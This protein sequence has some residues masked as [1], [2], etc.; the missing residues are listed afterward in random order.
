M[1]HARSRFSLPEPFSLLPVGLYDNQFG[2][3]YSQP[4]LRNAGGLLDRTPY[5]T[6]KISVA[7]AALQAEE[8]QETFLLELAMRFVTWASLS[9]QYD[10]TLE[11]LKLAEKQYDR[12]EDKHR[13]FLVDKI[14]VLRAADAVRA[15]E[16]RVRLMQS[17]R[18]A[19]GA[20]LA[21]L[22]QDS[23]L[24]QFR[25]A[26]D[27]E[28]RAPLPALGDANRLLQSPVRVL[29]VFELRRKV[30]QREHQAL[31]EEKKPDLSLQIGVSRIGGG[32][33]ERNLLNANKQD[34][35]VGL[36]FTMPLGNRIATARANQ[37]S[38]RVRQIEL[39]S[40][41]TTLELEALLHNLLVQLTELN[42]VITIDDLQ[43]ASARA[44]TAE[45]L[46]QYN[47]G[48]SDLTFVIQ[49]QDAEQ[50]A[51]LLRIRNATTYHQL[52]LQLDGLLDRFSPAQARPSNSHNGG[53]S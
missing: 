31:L 37:G 5:E 40:Q 22:A 36:R 24:R 15:G 30:A 14:D 41:Q 1:G 47:Q 35:S 20:E 27:F 2:I 8:D 42:K 16:A 49:A 52:S 48:R 32:P 18:D 39:L 4:L 7:I 44:K 10:I 45:E 34:F 11:R 25:P 53:A 51:R 43:I 23:Q 50:D 21:V 46:E 19:A 28:S 13:N 26:F 33:S 9:E 38:A 6:S 17:Q 3:L 29:H 12:T